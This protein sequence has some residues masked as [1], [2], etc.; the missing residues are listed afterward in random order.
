[1]IPAARVVVAGRARNAAGS[2]RA[3]AV[4]SPQPADMIGMLSVMSTSLYTGPRG[5][6][7][8]FRGLEELRQTFFRSPARLPQGHVGAEGVASR[9]L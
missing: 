9:W 7:I 6:D 5:P 8:G 1:M 3:A 4:G 2:V